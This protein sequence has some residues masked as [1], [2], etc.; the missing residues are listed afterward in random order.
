MHMLFYNNKNL[1]RWV[2][3]LFQYH[4]TRLPTTVTTAPHSAV[5]QPFHDANKN[6]YHQFYYTSCNHIPSWT[7][8][9]VEK[10]QYSEGLNLHRNDMSIKANSLNNYNAKQPLIIMVYP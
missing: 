7:G 4:S 5:I 1:F 9:G 10:R 2:N 8:H 6:N 3:G